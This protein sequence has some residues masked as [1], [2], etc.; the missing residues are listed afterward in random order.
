MGVSI[1]SGY[2]GSPD[3]QPEV[4]DGISLYENFDCFYAWAKRLR[5][6]LAYVEKHVSPENRRKH[7][8]GFSVYYLAKTPRYTVRLHHYPSAGETEK[9]VHDHVFKSRSGVLGG[10]IYETV[11]DL[12]K[13]EQG[14]GALYCFDNIEGK[15]QIEDSD[16]KYKMKIAAVNELRRG[17]TFDLLPGKIHSVAVS[18]AAITLMVKTTSQAF[19]KALV[20]KSV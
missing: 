3:R 11:Y 13:A 9:D 18:D 12:E 6:P 5:D 8:V 10:T 16:E 7:A 14:D 15:Q 17:D 1:P 2:D 20:I 4:D 19:Q